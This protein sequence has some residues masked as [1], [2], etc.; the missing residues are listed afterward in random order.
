VILAV[1]ID[2]DREEV[3]AY[4]ESLA[5]TFPTLLDEGGT[6]ARAYGVRGVPT[7]VLVD[8]E[9]MIQLQRVG[10]LNASLVEEYLVPA[11]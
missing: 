4:T 6:V 11:L 1:N 3:E 9:G 10:P 2:E 8:R 5:L 7:N